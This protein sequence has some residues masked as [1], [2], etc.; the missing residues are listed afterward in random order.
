MDLVGAYVVIPGAPGEALVGTSLADVDADGLPDVWVGGTRA[1]Y[2]G[3][4]LGDVRLFLG[5]DL[6][7]SGSSATA[8][9]EIYGASGP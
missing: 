5:A 8:S 2:A 4:W 3:T 9:A 6:V 7:A 1:E